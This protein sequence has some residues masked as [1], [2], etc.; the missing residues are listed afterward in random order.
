MNIKLKTL[1][2]ILLAAIAAI[3]L[4]SC[5]DD[6]IAATTDSNL[7]G[8]REVSIN[9][10]SELTSTVSDITTRASEP[11]NDLYAI[12]IANS[13]SGRTDPDFLIYGVFDGDHL[14]DL[15]VTLDNYS[16]YNIF[17]TMVADAKNT[18]D[19]EYNLDFD[20]ET[21]E[22]LGVEEVEDKYGQP[23]D[24]YKD[25]LNTF[26]YN[27]DFWGRPQYGMIYSYAN[28]DG[29]YYDYAYIPQYDRY[30]GELLNFK[31][32]DG[33]INVNMLHMSFGLTVNVN[34]LAE[35]D[36]LVLSPPT[37]E[38]YGRLKY[39]TFIGDNTGKATY[40]TIYTIGDDL[41]SY[42]DAA[43]NDTEESSSNIEYSFK[44]KWV[45]ADGTN[46]NPDSDKEYK[47]SFRRLKNFEINIDLPTSESAKSTSTV[48][49]LRK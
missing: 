2:L 14:N 26:L 34:N 38:D 32:S 31:P 3:G 9:L 36:T 48:S 8:K 15:K 44:V 43:I 18:L 49:Y 28:I 6:D 24:I 37:E 33:D 46:K 12:A 35:G 45:G 13:L 4:W 20:D 17:V 29:E 40:S 30:Y 22:L 21:Y 25:S 47:E 1:G 23:F 19:P 7:T 39:I 16:E 5:G 42:Y 10:T 11:S 41:Q 27:G